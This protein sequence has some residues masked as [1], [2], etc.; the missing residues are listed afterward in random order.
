M[1]LDTHYQVVYG[2]II[3]DL[4][5]F[6]NKS[7]LKPFVSMQSK[8]GEAV[9]FDTIAPD[10]EAD[11]NLMSALDHFRTNYDDIVTPVLADFVDLFTPNKK[12]EKTRTVCFPREIDFP[13]WFR[14]VDEVQENANNNSRV[15]KQGM[16]RMFKRQDY[17]ILDA[18]LKAT[19][20][21]GKTQAALS[22]IPFPA[23][24]TVANVSSLSTEVFSSVLAIFETNFAADE[25]IFMVIEP[26]DK[27][28]LIDAD[29]STIHSKDFV[30]AKGYFE[31]GEL[32]DIYGVHVIVHPG[33]IA[34]R[35][36]GQHKY[37][38]WSPDGIIYNQFTGL[39][40]KLEESSAMRF[41]IALQVQEDI[42][43]C[44]I[45]DTLVVQGTI[46]TP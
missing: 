40:V 2:D 1:A 26:L 14:N 10:D 11:D 21:R 12:V 5:G 38:A 29:G 34:F 15:L 17:H 41:Q 30:D 25:P 39:S 22:A 9:F 16:K 24:Q 19:E 42:G 23:G 7:L 27:K 28:A 6:Q 33:L 44:R 18:L 4:A 32:P 46:G 35:N 20:Q 8:K 3:Q 45:D 31:R 37:A 43:T 13:H 36:G